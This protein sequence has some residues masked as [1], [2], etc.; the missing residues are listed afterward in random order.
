MIIWMLEVKKEPQRHRVTEKRRIEKEAEMDHATEV[1]LRCGAGV[2]VIM[3][4]GLVV[5]LV[6]GE[7]M[8][9]TAPKG[10]EVEG[11]GFVRDVEEK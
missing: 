9:H 8:E 10:E 11:V 5:L 4:V 6:V 7:I 3:L 2:V 1:F